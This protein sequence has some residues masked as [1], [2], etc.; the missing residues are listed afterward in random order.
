MVP[1]HHNIISKVY[2]AELVYNLPGAFEE[3]HKKSK[4]LIFI[5]SYA[6]E[7]Y[8][9]IIGEAV[10]NGEV[11]PELPMLS[12]A[13][14]VPHD[15][16]NVLYVGR[17]V[18]R[19]GVTYLIDA[20]KKMKDCVF[21]IVGN[22]PEKGSLIK[23]ADGYDN[24]IFHGKIPDENLL[25]LYSIADVFVLPAIVDSRGDTEGLGVVLIEAMRSGVPCIASNVGGIR[26]IIQ[27]E[28][29][30]LLVNQKNSEEIVDAIKRIRYDDSL[31]EELVTTAHAYLSV[32]FS[33]ETVVRRMRGAI[34][35]VI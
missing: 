16:F 1:K 14:P 11:S 10:D 12:A 20:A 22:G 26:D 8:E 15:E 25:E 27:H 18:E 2:T 34:D 33:W 3:I 13:V 19:K 21:H 31:K 4:K 29:T 30:G 6:Q 9:R 23:Q 35:G 5:S 32:Y 7:K 24:I 28:K 17:L